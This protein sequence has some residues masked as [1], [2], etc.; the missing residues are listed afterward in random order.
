M[1]D[2]NGEWRRLHT[3]E[4]HSFYRSHNIFRVIKSRR[5]SWA[6]H[7]ARMQEDMSAFKILIGKATGK[8][9]LEKP[10]RRWEDNIRME[11]EEI[12]INTRN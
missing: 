5:L 9:P 8:R 6:G 1:R 12:C 4:I 11:L 3:E 2:D 10:R 7:L